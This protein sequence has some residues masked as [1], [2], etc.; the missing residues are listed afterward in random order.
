MLTESKNDWKAFSSPT[1]G[2]FSP[3]I[4]ASFR[5]ASSCVTPGMSASISTKQALAS[6]HRGKKLKLVVIGTGFVSLS[7]LQYIDTDLYDVTV[8]SPRPYFLFTP[9][10]ESWILSKV[11]IR[12]VVQPL[13]GFIRSVDFIRA[14]CTAIDNLNK[15]IT[16]RQNSGGG[17]ISLPYDFLV[18]GAGAATNT[19][20]I[21]AVREHALF[22]KDLGDAREIKRRILEQVELAAAPKLTEAEKKTLLNFTVVGTGPEGIEFA[23]RLND[24]L[25]SVLRK[26]S[27][28]LAD[29]AS[30]TLLHVKD[31]DA[32]DNADGLS[33][34][35]LRLF[36]HRKIRVIRYVR[37]KDVLKD[38]VVLED[39]TRISFGLLVW[40]VESAPT[41]LIRR[42]DYPK[43]KSGRIL[44]DRYM[45]VI[46]ARSVLAAGDCAAVETAHLPSLAIVAQ[47]EG[48]YLA[49]YL[50]SV[51]GGR[52]VSEFPERDLGILTH[53]AI[54]S[55]PFTRKRFR[56]N[57]L[58][59]FGIWR[60]ALFTGLAPARNNIYHF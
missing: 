27:P 12:S 35:T 53:L 16:C 24:A 6:R 40:S 22:L 34:Y 60:S 54:T 49:R 31:R 45:R 4:A 30:V 25:K 10:L 8:V 7:L 57:R 46:G 28:S 44:T 56:K 50:N 55:N 18:I 11:G 37:V 41:D 14:E 3:S 5:E 19:F 58:G 26:S 9:L 59:L 15:T 52:S 20:G 42:M 47:R 1:I 33:D 13:S 23:F 17:E 32:R 39:G 2:D 51:A 21:P 48:K 36:A 43:D 38:A 29:L